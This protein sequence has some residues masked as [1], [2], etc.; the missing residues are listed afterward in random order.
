[1]STRRMGHVP[2]TYLGL[3]GGP[4]LFN[5]ANFFLQAVG[6]NAVFDEDARGRVA[7]EQETGTR[8]DMSCK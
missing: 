7:V 8:M 5:V 1:M 3:S 4:S 2:G 6:L